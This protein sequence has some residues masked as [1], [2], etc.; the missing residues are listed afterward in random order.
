M[1]RRYFSVAEVERLIPTLEGIFLQVL[2][3]RAALRLQEQA[4]ERAGVRLSRQVLEEEGSGGTGIGGSS[5]G[6]GG[7]ARERP[8]V[9]RPKALFRAYY[10]ALAEE[11][12]RV[13]EL[14]GEVK[15]LDS[16]L[17]DFPGRRGDEDILLCWKLGE[18]RI[19]F[20]HTADSGFAGRRPI[21]DLVPREPQRLD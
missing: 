11:L 7:G 14:G 16:G 1:P 10:Q 6:G 8:E 18:K 21:D 5:G 12:A 9:R 3:L 15:D 13:S 4:L 20:W 17:V 19:G 2:Q